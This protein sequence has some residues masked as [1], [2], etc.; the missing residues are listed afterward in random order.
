[1]RSSDQRPVFK[2]IPMLARVL[3]PEVMDTQEEAE[4]YDAMGHDEVNRRFCDDLLAALAGTWPRH[5]VDVGTGT[6]RIPIDLVR[7]VPECHVVATDLSDHMLAVARRNVAAAGLEGR[8]E[9]TRVDAKGSGLPARA[10]DV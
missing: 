6:A 2:E 1:M 9:L 7:R 3:E 5:T 4:E 8:I 10:F